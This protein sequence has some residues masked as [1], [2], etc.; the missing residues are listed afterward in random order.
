MKNLLF[1][2]LLLPQL[3]FSQSW[4]QYFQL[5]DELSKDKYIVLPLNDMRRTFDST[6]VVIG[7]RHDIDSKPERSLDMARI[8]KG[9]GFRASDFFPK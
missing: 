3:A 5:M 8:E 1:A 4:N 7:M 6:K 9:Y 2:L